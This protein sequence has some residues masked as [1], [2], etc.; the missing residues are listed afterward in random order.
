MDL[1]LPLAARPVSVGA[2]LLPFR[3]IS[4]CEQ[5]FISWAGLRG[6]VPTAAAPTLVTLIVRDGTALVPDHDAVPA[7]PALPQ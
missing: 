6:A 3:G 5:A 4:W 2:C 1:A 7:A